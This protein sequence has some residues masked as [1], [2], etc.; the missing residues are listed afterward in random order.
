MIC[1]TICADPDKRPT[2]METERCLSEHWCESIRY[3]TPH[4]AIPS[5]VGMEWYP[6][7]DDAYRC[8]RDWAEHQHRQ[9]GKR[10]DRFERQQNV[11][12]GRRRMHSRS[13]SPERLRGITDMIEESSS[14]EDSIPSPVR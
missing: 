14:D 8:V 11:G 10:R 3:V 4:F 9:R 13:G 7:W 12:Q 1:R 5:H 6:A 2:M